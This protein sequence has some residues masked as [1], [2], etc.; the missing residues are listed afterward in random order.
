MEEQVLPLENAV[1]F[2]CSS[3]FHVSTTISVKRR[4]HN[5]RDM[6]Q[7]DRKHIQGQ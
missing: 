1:S 7:K 2:A 3:H 6:I 5:F 4:E